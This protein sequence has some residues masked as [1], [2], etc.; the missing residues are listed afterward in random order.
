MEIL[1]Q[2]VAIVRIKK[3][4]AVLKYPVNKPF[5]T[6]YIYH[7]TNQ[8]DLARAQKLRWETSV[9]GGLTRKYDC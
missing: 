9:I 6:E 5:R 1:T 2:N 7:D 4:N 8:T 3:A